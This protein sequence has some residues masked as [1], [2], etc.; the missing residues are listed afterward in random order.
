[1]IRR[2]RCAW[3]RGDVRHGVHVRLD[4]RKSDNAHRGMKIFMTFDAQQNTE[5]ALPLSKG[6]C[7]RRASI[8][9]A[10]PPPVTSAV[11]PRKE[12]GVGAA[13]LAPVRQLARGFSSSGGFAQKTTSCSCTMR[14]RR[15]KFSAFSGP[16]ESQVPD[17]ATLGNDA[18]GRAAGNYERSLWIRMIQTR[19]HVLR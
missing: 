6:P 18:R 14:C 17:D 19:T 15:C 2:F 8:R 4:V 11:Q 5:V 13:A 16:C 3:R 12:L 7:G 9:G 1:M 10:R